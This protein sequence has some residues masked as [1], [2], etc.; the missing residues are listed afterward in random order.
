M[1]KK[2]LST[3]LAATLSFTMLVGCGSSESANETSSTNEAAS[4]NEASE[5]AS[6]EVVEDAAGESA[7]AEEKSEEAATD[8]PTTD[9][10][11]NEI[12]VPEEIDAI[13]SMSPSSTRLLVDLGLSDYIVACDTY[14]YEYYG[15]SL[16]ADIPQ[17]DMMSPDQES[18]V[19]LNPDIVFTTG[20]S[21][22]TGTDVYGSVRE[23]GICVADIPSASSLEDISTSI[24]FIGSCTGTADEAATIVEEMEA[25]I[26][27]IKELAATISEDEKKTVLY[28][29]NTPTADYPTIYSAG[30]ETYIAE[31]IEAIGAVNATADQVGWASLTEEDAIAINPDVIISTDMYTTDAVETHLTLSGWENVT[32]V[33]NGDVY[34]M[35]LSNELNQPNQHVVSAMV[36]MAKYIYPE[37]FADV[38]DPFAAVAR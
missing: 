6:E 11:G 9:L 27:E 4:T 13:V 19:A 10:A 8:L 23:A 14:S 3:M 18:I 15:D 2:L 38:E 34:L 30:S 20:M 31:M 17:F 16:T 26:D 21:Y 5:S 33:V 28:E 24:T 22:A 7:T 1:K 35:E 32:A 37:V 36:E 12:T 29:T 25:T